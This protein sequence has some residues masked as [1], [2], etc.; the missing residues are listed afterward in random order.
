MPVTLIRGED[1]VSAALAADYGTVC[2]V[3]AV[4]DAESGRFAWGTMLAAGAAVPAWLVTGSETPAALAPPADLAA[5]ST[6]ALAAGRIKIL[7]HQLARPTP[8]QIRA[9]LAEFDYYA[10]PARSL[11]VIDCGDNWFDQ[12]SRRGRAP[13]VDSL[14]QWAQRRQ[15]AVLLLFHAATLGG[16]DRASAL[17]AFARHL[18]GIARLARESR[19]SSGTSVTSVTSVTS[20]SPNLS[21]KPTGDP[22]A[23]LRCRLLYWFGSTMQADA[24]LTLAIGHD[25]TLHAVTEASVRPERRAPT[26]TGRVVAQ[27][28]ALAGSGGAPQHWQVCESLSEVLA[29]CADAVAATVILSFERTTPHDALMQAVY[30]LRQMADSQL[31]IIVRELH[32]RMRYN[33]DALI[34][35][36]GASLIVPMEVSYARFLSMMEM[37]Q[38]QVFTGSLPATFEAALEDGLPDQA[39]GYLPPPAFARAVSDTLARSRT[40]AIDNVLVR[41]TLANGLTPLDAM[42]HCSLKRAGDLFTADRKTVLVFLFAC[43]E[44]DATQTLERIFALPVGELFGSEHR[45]IANLAAQTA[46]EEFGQ[47]ASGGRLPDLSDEL[48][49]IADLRAPMTSPPAASASFGASGLVAAAAAETNRGARSSP[50]APVHTP[51]RL[52]TGSANVE[53]LAQPVG[54]RPSVP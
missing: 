31:K 36:L 24:T 49:R 48:Q 5:A 4:G 20:D 26:D 38:N 14:R 8:G 27:R 15:V 9:L 12:A 1:G 13:L 44:M 46:I 33:E 10:P 19:R 42:R 2:A 18:G 51:L 43:R 45:Y 34:A 40:L 16:V 11:M 17:L 23:A 30:R 29:A 54:L 35:R 52:R 21:G 28:S 39:L 6:D 37:L 47:R 3:C 50:D 53:R 7:R 22:S 25:G 32:V 41:L